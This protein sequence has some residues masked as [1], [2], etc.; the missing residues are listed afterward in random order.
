MIERHGIRQLRRDRPQGFAAVPRDDELRRIPEP[1]VGDRRGLGSA[2]RPSGGRGRRRVLR[3]RRRLQRRPE[4]GRHRPA[5]RE[6]A[7]PR[8]GRRRDQGAR[9]HDARP[10]WTGTRAQAHPRLDRRVARP[11]R[12][13]LRRPV[14]D[15]PLGRLDADRGDDGGAPR[16]RAVGQGAVSRREQHVRLAVRESA[17]RRVASRVDAIRLDA[18]PLQPD[19]P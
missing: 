4:R 8:G 2:D 5:S 18:E 17:G 13:R 9:R 12:P 6:G 1:A 7:L 15:P 10:E 14:P 3:H 19:L 16:R 11:S